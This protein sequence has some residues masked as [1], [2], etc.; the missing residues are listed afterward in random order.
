MVDGMP[1]PYNCKVK[2]R[3]LFACI[4]NPLLQK[5]ANLRSTVPLCMY[6]L[7]EKIGTELTSSGEE[8]MF[9]RS[10]R[11]NSD[12]LS[13]Y[14]RCVE[15]ARWHCSASCSDGCSRF[16][17]RL[18]RVLRHHYG[19]RERS[20]GCERNAYIFLTLLISGGISRKGSKITNSVSYENFSE[21]IPLALLHKNLALV[22]L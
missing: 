20:L 4:R 19:E 17:H 15:L 2:G 16:Q 9:I 11:G 6:L 21:V 12:H 18:H 14:V 13:R 1:H 3:S 22:K 7:S 8:K 10:T 5:L